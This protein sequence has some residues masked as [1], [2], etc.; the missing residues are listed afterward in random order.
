MTSILNIDPAVFDP[1]SI[2][3][4]TKDMNARLQAIMDGAPK[5][6][7]VGAPKYRQMR[8]AG[9]TPLPAATH[10]PSATDITIPSRDASRT[11][12]CRVL[13]PTNNTPIRGTFL[14][15]HG[16]GWVLQDEKSQDPPLQALADALG[17]ACISV[18][19]R[20]APEHPYPAGPN[21]CY[22]AA[23][24]L[25]EHA[26]SLLG[27][28]LMFT[29]GESAG[30]HL[31][32]LTALHLLQHPNPKF[33]RDFAFQGLLLHFGSYTFR[34][35]PQVYTWQRDPPLV[36]DRDLMEHYRDAF[37]PGWQDAERGQGTQ[38]RLEDPAV[39]PLY[40]DLE[41]LRG[42][43]PD[44]LF[45]C[46]TEDPLL[47]DSLLMAAKWR[48]AGGGTETLIVPG[49]PHGFIMFPRTMEGARSD[50]GMAL[51]EKFVGKRLE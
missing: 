28:P 2:T 25:V 27:A 3:Q 21:D 15:I 31:A 33:S 34:W 30:A 4:A 29:G 18:G 43:L 12:P 1:A 8:A 32:L 17:L 49:A 10:L 40:A 19:Y 44:A 38:V 13:K 26:P 42:R 7:E 48:V 46:G 51:V 50:E 20:L 47:D 45:T 16:G 23:E 24:Y 35:L 22:D 36:L 39:S 5:W 6:Y 11:I 37:L 41:P 14:H 9:E